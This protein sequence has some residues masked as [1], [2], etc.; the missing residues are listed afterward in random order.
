MTTS[1]QSLHDGFAAVVEFDDQNLLAFLVR[2]WSTLQPL[3]E[4]D[5]FELQRNYLESALPP[6]A[7]QQQVWATMVNPIVT[8]LDDGNYELSCRFTWQKPSDSHSVTF[9]IE[10]GEPRGHSI[11]G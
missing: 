1:N 7:T 4:E 10:D 8:C 9:Y 11:D 6:S 2:D 5:A 3:L